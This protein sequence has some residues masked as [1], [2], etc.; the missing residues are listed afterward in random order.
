MRG[1]SCKG[2]GLISTGTQIMQGLA[3]NFDFYP[4]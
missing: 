4:E 3:K 1:E 2:L